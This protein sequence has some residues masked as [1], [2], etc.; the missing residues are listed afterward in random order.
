[1][2]R[3][4]LIGPIHATDEQL[5]QIG[6]FAMHAV[7]AALPSAKGMRRVASKYARG[8]GADGFFL[9]EVDG[10]ATGVLLCESK[11]DS[12][13]LV[14]GTQ[15]SDP[16]LV[17]YARLLRR[18]GWIERAKQVEACL[19]GEVPLL[20]KLFHFRTGDGTLRI[21]NLNSAG[22]CQPPRSERHC[23]VF[24]DLLRRFA[25]GELQL[26]GPSFEDE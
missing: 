26:R 2:L 25:E 1:M 10:Q 12:A 24:T 5:G 16:W 18:H 6:E 11:V 20:R 15:L 8:W 14:A 13:R 19:A 17:T 3:Q 23:A 21:W 4:T 9:R 22:R 7:A